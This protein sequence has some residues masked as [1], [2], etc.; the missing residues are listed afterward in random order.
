[1]DIILKDSQ[2]RDFGIEL[3]NIR[4]FKERKRIVMCYPGTDIDF[5]KDR[6]EVAHGSRKVIIHIGEKSIRNKDRTF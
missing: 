3:S 1:M 5:F 4:K 2:V 6:L